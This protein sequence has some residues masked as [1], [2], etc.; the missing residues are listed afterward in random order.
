MSFIPEITCRSCGKKFSA[1]RGRCPHCGTRHVKQTMRT[2]PV[3]A[4]SQTSP[5]A[6]ANAANN[7]HWQM[8]FGGILVAAV[9]IAV[10]ILIT[11]SLSPD[12]NTPAVST[13]PLADITTAPPATPDPTP[14]PSPTVAITSLTITYLG[15]QVEDITQRLSNPTIQL[16]ADVYP[17]EALTTA[18]VLW[19]S[20]D[21]AVATVDETGLVTAVG[22]GQCQII[23]ECGGMSSSC[24]VRVP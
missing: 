2:T 9:I 23:A 20:S 18:T 4:T 11:A 5:T 3:T 1:L 14:T 13:P 7:V 6:A 10:I 24:L 8:I 22:R 16:S 15:R 19:R 12:E 17:R 21:S